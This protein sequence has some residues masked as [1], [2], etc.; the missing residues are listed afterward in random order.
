MS[1]IYLVRHG[2]T[3]WNKL[4]RSQ[5]CGNDISLS[6]EGFKQARAVAE[7]LGEEKIDLVFSSTLLRA[8]QTAEEIAKLHNLK[9]EKCSEFM[10]INFGEWEGMLFPDIKEKFSEAY[11]VWRTTPHLAVIP[12]A[13]NV[14]E[15]RDR[16]MKKLLALIKENPDKN[17]VV[18]SHGIS[19]KVLITA[20]MNIDL[21][22]LHRVRQDNTAINIFEYENNVFDLV[23]LNDICH[24][25]GIVDMN[26]GSFEMK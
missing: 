20:I 24:L 18:V 2:E 10:E 23:T 8:Y 22:H 14:A 17:I 3:E 11:E 4:Q 12:G 7:R 1:R 13:E 19:I 21:G 26:N 6:E 16:S 15:L 9:V 25:R 5:G